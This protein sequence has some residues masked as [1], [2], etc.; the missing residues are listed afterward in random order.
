MPP[1]GVCLRRIGPADAMVIVVVVVSKHN[2]TQL[3]ASNY[4]TFLLAKAKYFC[5]LK[6]T[7]YSRH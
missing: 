2:K 3:L 6:G 5:N 1:L 4:R 7:L